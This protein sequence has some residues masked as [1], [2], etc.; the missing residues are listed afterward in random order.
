MDA[1]L[2]PPAVQLSVA[3][4]APPECTPKLLRPD[5]NASPAELLLDN[6]VD[7]PH[8]TWAVNVDAVPE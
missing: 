7:P 8:V 6:T 4:C 3:H 2:A 5:R 1:A